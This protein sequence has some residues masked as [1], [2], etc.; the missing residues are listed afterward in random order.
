MEHLNDV[1]EGRVWNNLRKT[2][3]ASAR[4]EYFARQTKEEKKSKKRIYKNPFSN[5][6]HDEK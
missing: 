2:Q 3:P 6:F 4:A 1:E 5:I